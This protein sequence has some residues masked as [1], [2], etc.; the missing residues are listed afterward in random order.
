MY[1]NS[2]ADGLDSKIS[3]K[4]TLTDGLQFNGSVANAPGELLFVV[5]CEIIIF[6]ETLIIQCR[7][8][9]EVRYIYFTVT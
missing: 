9:F 4:T 5:D 7:I 1:F 3:F 2:S 6:Y 8:V